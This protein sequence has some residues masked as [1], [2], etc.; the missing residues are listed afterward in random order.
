[1]S[2]GVSEAST[3]AAGVGLLF[4]GSLGL[5]LVS[6]AMDRFEMDKERRRVEAVRQERDRCVRWVECTLALPCDV[7]THVRLHRL[8][9]AIRSGS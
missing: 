4:V 5:S 7:E 6:I 2:P 1:V 9:D 3:A 8:L